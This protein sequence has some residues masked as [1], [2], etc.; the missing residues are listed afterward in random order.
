MGKS[1]EVVLKNQNS[2]LGILW[3]KIK[4]KNNSKTVEIFVQKK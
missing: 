2:F 3:I 1:L 4:Q